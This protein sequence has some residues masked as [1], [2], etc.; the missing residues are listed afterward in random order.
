MAT[1]RK[2]I[3]RRQIGGN[4]EYQAWREVFEVGHDGFGDLAEFGIIDPVNQIIPMV[5]LP[6]ARAAFH[7]VKRDAWRRF[8]ARFMAEWTPTEAHKFPK[9]Y[10]EFGAP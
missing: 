7:E 4:A 9:A 3:R 8:G 2:P 10:L 1:K 5:E 6:A